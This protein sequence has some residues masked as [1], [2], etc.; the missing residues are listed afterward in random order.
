VDDLLDVS[1][2]TQGRIELRK[3]PT[4]LAE[5]IS[6]AL[7]I[8]APTIDGRNQDLSV[9]LPEDPV[10]LHADVIRLAQVVGNLLDNA[11]KCTEVGEKLW[12]IATGDPE[13]AVVKVR[14]SGIG[15]P[16]D[17]LAHIFEPFQRANC[18]VDRS[19]GG[20]GLGLTLV[21]S[22]VKLHGGNVSAFSRGPRQGSEFI[23]RLPVLTEPVSE[24]APAVVNRL[25][26][27]ERASKRILVVDDESDAA[28]S[29]AMLLET[30]GHETCTAT[31]GPD[32]LQTVASFRPQVVILDL[33]LPGMDGYEIARRLR[34]A[35]SH[36]SLLL[37]ALTGYGQ[38]ENRRR[39]QEVGIDNYL[40]KPVDD[41]ALESLIENFAPP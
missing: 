8:V 29:L 16:E 14:D 31:D 24:A 17:M 15:I 26:P 27:L 7:E 40:T 35:R 9:S 41:N 4:K 39:S 23:I 20:L 12:L 2:I 10:W 5:V 33:G 13:E 6:R 36:Q 28:L 34:R 21:R 30:M 38:E 32:A 1:R 11:S 25:R 3:A 19:D 37:V 18:P 22:L